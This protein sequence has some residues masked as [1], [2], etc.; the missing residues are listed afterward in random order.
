MQRR[1]KEPQET[2]NCS[3]NTCIWCHPVETSH[4]GGREQILPGFN[5]QKGLRGRDYFLDLE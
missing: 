1:E 5:E 3:F 2:Q 4:F